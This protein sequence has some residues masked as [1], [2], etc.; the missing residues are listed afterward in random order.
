MRFASRNASI[1]T[2]ASTS[3]CDSLSFASQRPHSCYR[4]PCGT[5]AEDAPSGKDRLRLPFERAD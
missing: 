1:L 2:Q 3:Y 4:I 5:D